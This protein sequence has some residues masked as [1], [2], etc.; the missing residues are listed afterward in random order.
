V[1]QFGKTENS[2]VVAGE[3]KNTTEDD[4]SVSRLR[5]KF[6]DKDGAMLDQCEAYTYQVQVKRGATEM[7]KAACGTKGTSS[8]DQNIILPDTLSKAVRA[9]VTATSGFKPTKLSIF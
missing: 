3:V 4:W 6:Y 2:I 8:G 5:I 1:Q 7:F 9:E